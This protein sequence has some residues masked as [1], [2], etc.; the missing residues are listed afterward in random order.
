MT[1][2]IELLCSPTSSCTKS[3][4]EESTDPQSQVLVKRKKAENP[5]MTS[6]VVK[7]LTANKRNIDKHIAKAIFATNSSFR[8]IQHVQ[9]KKAIQPLRPG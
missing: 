7:I 4:Q 6:F 5:T 8:C 3:S 2:N 1:F 9:V